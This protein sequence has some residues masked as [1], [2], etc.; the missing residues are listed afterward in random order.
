M[1][2]QSS[3]G[4]ARI[5]SV[6]HRQYHVPD[7]ICCTIPRECVC[8]LMAG[9]NQLRSKRSIGSYTM[10]RTAHLINRCWVAEYGS[11][12]DDLG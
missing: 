1:R 10:H 8:T 2:W 6:G 12:S 9:S 11:I 3:R 5:S 7:V 4:L